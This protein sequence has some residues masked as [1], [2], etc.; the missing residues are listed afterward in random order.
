M[1]TRLLLV[2]D[3]DWF[4]RL[5]A[6]MLVTGGYDV[7]GEAATATDALRAARLLQPDLV[8][9]DVGLPDGNGFEVADQLAHLRPRPV[10]VLISSRQ[11]DDYV[12]RLAAAPVAGFL[13]KDELTAQALTAV[14]DGPR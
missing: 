5:A 4:R 6:A 9:L 12:A 8:L 7:V 10:V 14:L 3:H 13:S 1:R 11:R 2:D